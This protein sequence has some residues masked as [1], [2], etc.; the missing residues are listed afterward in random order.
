MTLAIVSWMKNLLKNVP[1]SVEV[2]KQMVCKSLPEPL[3]AIHIFIFKYISYLYIYIYIPGPSKGCQMVLRGVN[4][5]SLRVYL[6][7]L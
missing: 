4:E 1:K 5:P 3:E 7:P 2:K 6:A